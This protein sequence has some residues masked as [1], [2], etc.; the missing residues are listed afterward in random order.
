MWLGK[1]FFTFF[2]ITHGSQ[3][4]KK[5]K[6]QSTVH[7]E[8]VIRLWDTNTKKIQNIWKHITTIHTDNITYI[9]QF[10]IVFFV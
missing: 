9:I 6:E 10:V 8:K 7:Q 1:I 4:L 3:D 2:L 5:K